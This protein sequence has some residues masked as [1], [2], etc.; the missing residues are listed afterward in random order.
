VFADAPGNSAPYVAERNRGIMFC[1]HLNRL[2]ALSRIAFAAVCAGAALA[3]SPAWATTC[4]YQIAMSE[5]LGR[6]ERT[7]PGAPST[8]DPA[9]AP[10]ITSTTSAEWIYLRSHPYVAINNQSDDGV[11]IQTLNIQLNNLTGLEG[12]QNLSQ[13]NPTI[14]VYA[15]QAFDGAFPSIKSVQAI[16]ASGSTGSSIMLTFNN[17][18]DPG[19]T[20]IFRLDLTPASKKYTSFADYRL[21]LS[22]IDDST[23]PNAKN[24]TSTVT[25]NSPDESDPNPSAGGTFPNIPS[26]MADQTSFSIAYSCLNSPDGIIGVPGTTGT[27]P[28]VPEPSTALLAGLGVVGILLGRTRLTGKKT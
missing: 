27:T 13:F 15:F 24:A 6:L 18:F 4:S 22:T 23:T 25:F 3:N 28:Q 19:A 21:V 16:P 5:D 12:I 10:V 14:D 1:A 20:L 9:F 7:L 2:G 8:G 17:N 26:D 11:S